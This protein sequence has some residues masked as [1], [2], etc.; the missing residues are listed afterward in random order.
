MERITKQQLNDIVLHGIATDIFIAERAYAMFK[1]IGEQ[2]HILLGND[3][4]G[5]FKSAQEAFKDQF[6]LAMSR[7][8]D[9]PSD[10]NFTRCIR[11]LIDFLARN[12]FRLPEII[13]RENLW[14][15]MKDA[16]FDNETLE[17]VLKNH[18]DVE[19]LKRIVGHYETLLNS[20]EN[21]RKLLKLREIRDRR[22]AHN[23]LKKSSSSEL[24]ETINI[25]TFKD[26]FGLLNIAKQFVGI[27]GWSFMSMVFIIDGSYHLTD[28]AERP[29]YS[30]LA[31]FD[32]LNTTK[33]K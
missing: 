20:P 29:K 24:T 15:V 4:Q 5:F 6:L 30:L 10:R 23:E 22:L 27:I 21:S 19:V 9:S 31:L 32:Q 28:D 16:N 8:F 25:I 7:L 17:L 33:K 1:T 12:S 26:L 18:K 2:S 13:E 3:Y 14:H 11:G